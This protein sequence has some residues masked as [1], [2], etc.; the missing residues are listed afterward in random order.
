LDHKLHKLHTTGIDT[1]LFSDQRQSRG[2]Q[3]TELRKAVSS[4]P[5]CEELL[6]LHGM[7]FENFT[8][9]AGREDRALLPD[10]VRG[11]EGGGRRG[12]RGP[13]LSRAAR[14]AEEA[15]G[16]RRVVEEVDTRDDGGL[17]RRL[18]SARE[19]VDWS[20]RVEVVEEEEEA[21]TYLEEE[22]SLAQ[23]DLSY[24]EKLKRPRMGMVADMVEKEKR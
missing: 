8:V 16:G 11:A 15:R 14:E 3:V 10:V 2:H 24:S 13:L 6:Q 22:P 20:E 17:K 12:D 23:M 5:V 9:R 4:V 7:K 19:R 21:V 18:G 1:F